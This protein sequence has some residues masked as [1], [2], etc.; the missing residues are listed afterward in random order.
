VPVLPTGSFNFTIPTQDLAKGLRWTRRNPRNEK[1]LTECNG[2]VGINNVLR[3]LK[4][5]NLSHLID[6]TIVTD[7][8]PYP[9]LFVFTNMILVCSETTIYEYTHLSPGT[10]TSK[11]T[12]DPGILWSAVDY[13]DYIY[14]SNCTVAVVRHAEDGSWEEVTNLP[15]ARAM[16][17]YNGQVVISPCTEPV[18][19][20]EGEGGENGENGEEEEEERIAP[21]TYIELLSSMGSMPDTFYSVVPEETFRPLNPSDYDGDITYEFEVIAGSHLL[22]DTP[23]SL[24]DESGNI[25]ATVTVPASCAGPTGQSITRFDRIAFTPSAGLH[26]YG[27]RIDGGPWDTCDDELHVWYPLYIADV[28]IVIKQVNATKTKVQVPLIGCPW[29][30]VGETFVDYG[31]PAIPYAYPTYIDIVDNDPLLTNYTDFFSGPWPCPYPSWLDSFY[32]SQWF[33]TIW[34]YVVAEHS[35][36]SGLQFR[37]MA[38]WWPIL[39]GNNQQI[40]TSPVG[41][42]SIKVVKGAP[43]SFSDIVGATASWTGD[44]GTPFSI[45][46]DVPPSSITNGD[47][48]WIE[49]TVDGVVSGPFFLYT[50]TGGSPISAL[51]TLYWPGIPLVPPIIEKA[52]LGSRLVIGFAGS[53]H[54]LSLALYDKTTSTIVPGSELTWNCYEGPSWKIATLDPV[55]LVDGHE[56]EVAVVGGTNTDDGWIEAPG[57]TD[58]EIWLT[59]DP[60]TTVSVWQRVTNSNESWIDGWPS[61]E[62][63]GATLYGGGIANIRHRVLYEVPVGA[64]PQT[65][66]RYEVT[67]QF[68]WEWYYYEEDYPL[69]S[70]W[71]RDT[72]IDDSEGYGTEVPDSVLQWLYPDEIGPRFLKQSPP[73]ALTSGHRYIDCQPSG[74]TSWLTPNNGFLVVRFDSYIL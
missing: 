38:G 45:N 72:D 17:N 40:N 23:V 12:V 47:D 6:S 59:L 50:V 68:Q 26:Y 62:D 56:Y 39:A 54:S 8:F 55:D 64:P 46:V 61:P 29:R 24:V 2:A 21:I 48:L 30:S 1:F 69:L 7:N 34:K 5:L 52:C 51:L 42:A 27:M 73:L 66:V 65:S 14:M 25:Y 67:G 60:A 49:W 63:W 71:L 20:R 44:E 43:G 70:I 28:R 4:D 19:P 18:V 3:T 35:T 10:L 9:Q 31:P 57:Y 33:L 53:G 15:A 41:S 22:T 32:W 74:D 36:L 11:I 16:C 58:A 37:A 13:H